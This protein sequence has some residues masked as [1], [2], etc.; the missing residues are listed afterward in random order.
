VDLLHNC[1]NCNAAGKIRICARV[2]C[3]V[4]DSCRCVSDT[5]IRGISVV[6]DIKI[7]D[8]LG[9]GVSDCGIMRYDMVDVVN[10]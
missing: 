4:G 7:A 5:L 8:F 1:S 3:Q 6:R 10:L 2:S 9:M